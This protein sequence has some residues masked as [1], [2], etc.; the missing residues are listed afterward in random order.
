MP[1]DL[2]RVRDVEAGKERPLQSYQAMKEDTRSDELA[3]AT[4]LGLAQGDSEGDPPQR[5][6]SRFIDS[7]RLSQSSVRRR[8]QRR[9]EGALQ[10]FETW[11]LNQDHFLGVWID[12]KHVAGEQETWCVGATEAGRKKVL[13][14]T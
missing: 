1:V 14:F 4:L 7:F 12:G 9:V 2:A 5:V 3:E 8:F 10:E 6:A 11:S 13:G